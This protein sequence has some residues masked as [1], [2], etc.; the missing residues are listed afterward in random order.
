MKEAG[1]SQREL[2]KRSGVCRTALRRMLMGGDPAMS[3]LER[4]LDCLGYDIDAIPRPDPVSLQSIENGA[5][6]CP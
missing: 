2:A 3:V 4:V 1:I 5:E 6:R